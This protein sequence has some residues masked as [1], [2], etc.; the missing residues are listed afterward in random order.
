MM[1]A[2]GWSLKTGKRQQV[3]TEY[4]AHYNDRRPHRSLDQRAPRTLGLAPVPSDKPDPTQ[5]CRRAVL[6]GIIHEYRLVA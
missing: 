5:L 3:L 1:L 4:A 6:G 2:T